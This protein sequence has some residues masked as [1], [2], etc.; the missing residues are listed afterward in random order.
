MN[1][2]SCTVTDVLPIE[3]SGAVQ[4]VVSI[5]LVAVVGTAIYLATRREPP[6]HDRDD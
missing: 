2:R 3:L 5:V 1:K 4:V 6:D